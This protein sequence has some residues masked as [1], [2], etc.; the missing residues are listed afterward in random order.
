MS[1]SIFNFNE[2]PSQERRRWFVQRGAMTKYNV[3]FSSKVEASKW[4][5]DLGN[6]LDWRVGFTFRLR[7]DSV[8]MHIVDR[9][10]NRAK[11]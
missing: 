2:V 4:I 8:D 3:G 7:G 1:E 6:R 9:F 11:N 10:G 5:D